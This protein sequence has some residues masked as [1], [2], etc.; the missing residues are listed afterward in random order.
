M[1]ATTTT[2]ERF[3]KS[4][5]ETNIKD[6]V[7]LRIKAAAIHCSYHIEGEEWV[8]ETEWNVIGEQ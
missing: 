8:I 3:P 6:L 7:K 5:P 1:P 4:V 2:I